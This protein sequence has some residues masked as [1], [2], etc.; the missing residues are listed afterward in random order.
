[1][2]RCRARNSSNIDIIDGQ[3]SVFPL[4]ARLLADIEIGIIFGGCK[5]ARGCCRFD[6]FPLIA[7]CQLPR[8]HFILAART[9]DYFQFHAAFGH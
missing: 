9:P 1:M 3:R 6:L 2:I 8:R 7:R 4:L 5:M